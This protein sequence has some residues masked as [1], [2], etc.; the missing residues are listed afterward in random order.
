MKETDVAS[1]AGAAWVE[2]CVGI[3]PQDPTAADATVAAYKARFAAHEKHLVK[4]DT[5]ASAVASA[6]RALNKAVKKCGAVATVYA[7]DEAGLG[8]DAA[9]KVGGEVGRRLEPNARASR[10]QRKASQRARPLAL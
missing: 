8:G 1:G 5:A 3:A 4:L 10:S 9:A 6:S 7:N 2:K